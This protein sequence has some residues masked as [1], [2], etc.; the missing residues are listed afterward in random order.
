MIPAGLPPLTSPQREIWFDQMLYQNVPLY[1]IGGQ[2]DLQG[3]MDPQLFAETAPLLVHN[4]DRLRR[5]L[6]SARDEDGV[7]LQTL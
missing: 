3:V 5:R 2:V 1:N 7:P 6:T 4:H